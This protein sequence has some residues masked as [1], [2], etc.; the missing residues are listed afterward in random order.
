MFGLRQWQKP[1]W[2]AAFKENATDDYGTQKPVYETPVE[3]SFNVQ[4]VNGYTDIQAFGERVSQMQKAV[5]PRAY[6]GRFGESD[7]A[8]LDGVTPSGEA[9]NGANANYVIVSVR[10]QNLA[11][12]I[13]FEKLQEGSVDNG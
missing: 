7:L 9:I 6:E 3:Y 1:V 5:V 8:Y 12:S 13:Y 4:P 11:M 2:I 10:V